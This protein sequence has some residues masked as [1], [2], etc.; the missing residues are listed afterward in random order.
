[1]ARGNNKSLSTSARSEIGNSFEF[2]SADNITNYNARQSIASRLGYLMNELPSDSARRNNGRAEKVDQA[3]YF[4][5]TPKSENKYFKPAQ[6]RGYAIAMGKSQDAFEDAVKNDYSF[7]QRYN[8]ILQDAGKV[9]RTLITE[10]AGIVNAS[11]EL[12]TAN[13]KEIGYERI[14]KAFDDIADIVNQVRVNASNIEQL[15]NIG[16]KG[17]I[18]KPNEIA[19]SRAKDLS[20]LRESNRDLF[21]GARNWD[22]NASIG[23]KKATIRKMF[24]IPDRRNDLYLGSY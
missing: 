10:T 12:K 14:G 13:G 3:I 11:L 8:G 21:D 20:Y 9:A 23:T 1:M 19:K 5:E 2:V 15:I 24:D 22:R 16:W 6:L 7:P 17:E 18:P 4:L